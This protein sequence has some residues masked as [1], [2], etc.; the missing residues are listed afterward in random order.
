MEK[1]IKKINLV[2]SPATS[3]HSEDLVSFLLASCAPAD[4]HPT[5]LCAWSLTTGPA[6][7]PMAGF[8]YEGGLAGGRTVWLGMYSP[9]SLSAR[10]PLPK[11][12]VPFKTQEPNKPLAPHRLW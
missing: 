11:V 10:S 1:S 8:G 5:F 4:A 12:T 9:R 7:F 2:R 6:S 3:S